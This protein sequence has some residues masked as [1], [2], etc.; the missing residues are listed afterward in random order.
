MR[1]LDPAE[2]VAS[3]RESLL[4]LTEELVVEYAND[5]FL[6]TFDVEKGATVG[7]RLAALGNGQWDIPALLD[8]LGKIVSGGAEVEDFEVDHVFERIGRRV[9]RLNARKT[10]RPGNGSRR[11]LLAIEDVTAERDAAAALERERL[12]SVGIVAT[13]REPLLVLDELLAVVSASR[14]FYTTFKV[15]PDATLGRRLDDLGNGQW[16]LPELL[17]LLADVVQKNTVVEDFEVSHSFPEIGERVVLLNAR[18]VFREGN[19]T[20]MLLLAM[21]DVT[22]QRRL[23]AER[24]AELGHAGRL[25]EELNHRVMNSLSI[26]GGIIG[27]EARTMGDTACKAAFARIRARIDAIGSLYRCLSHVGSVDTVTADTYL[28]ALVENV[29]ASSGH[30]ETLSIE[31]DI[32]DARLSTQVAVPLGLIVNELVT[33]SLKYAYQGRS[34]GRLGIE[35]AVEGPSMI[36]SVWDDGPGLDPGARVVSGLGQKLIDAF[37]GQLGGKMQVCSDAPGTR[38]TLILP[39]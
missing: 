1:Q 27:L 33:N 21:Q 10:V 37:T 38:H 16:A 11:I 7:S 15:D 23:E 4:V 29:V 6:R 14:S 36:V 2:I 39:L 20:H 12:L 18:K 5:R 26:I 17:G 3:L 30:A 34:D 8:E 19:H 31:F 13:L 32:S 25:L 22:G 24:E 28:T 9:M 35:L